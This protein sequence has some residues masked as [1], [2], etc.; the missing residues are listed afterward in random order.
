MIDFRQTLL[1]Q[2]ANSPVLME[3]LSTVSQY[4]D[5]GRNVDA[6]YDLVWNVR[7]AQGYGLDVWG[8]IVGVDRLVTLPADTDYLGFDEA[9][10][11]DPLGQAPMWNSGSEG[12]TYA[13]P[14]ETFR[15]LVLAKALANITKATVSGANEVLRRV[16]GAAAYCSNN[17]DMTVNLVFDGGTDELTLALLAQKDVLPLPTG[18]GVRS[19]LLGVSTDDTFGFAGTGFQPLDQGTFIPR[20]RYLA[21]N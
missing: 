12:S 8:R 2:F 21:A 16:A 4:L 18:V 6:L 19:M 9:G 17:G 20:G 15:G 14:D 7:T 10:D 1:C 11:W 13:L 5:A 3:I